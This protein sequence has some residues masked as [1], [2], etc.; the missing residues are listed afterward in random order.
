MWNMSNNM[1][2]ILL[3]AGVHIGLVDLRF[4]L[5]FVEDTIA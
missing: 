3:V 1:L 4:C 2:E 5:E